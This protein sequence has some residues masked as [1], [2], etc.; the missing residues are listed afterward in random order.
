LY[1][2]KLTLLTHRLIK[3][4]G[5]F[6]SR[7]KIALNFEFYNFLVLQIYRICQ[8]LANFNA[9]L[10]RSVCEYLNT[11]E[12]SFVDDR[13]SFYLQVVEL[14]EHIVAYL[15]VSIATGFVEPVVVELQEYIVAYL[16]VSIATG[17]VEPVVVELQEYIVAYIKM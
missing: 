15:K 9:L 12:I 1:N 5:I 4:H 7:S 13:D 17:F 11:G 6:F 16:K 14:Q 8:S 2:A 10:G 3:L